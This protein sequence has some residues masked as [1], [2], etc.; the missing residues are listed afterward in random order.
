MADMQTVSTQ[1]AAY[2]VVGD[3]SQETGSIT[4][5]VG[6]SGPPMVESLQAFDRKTGDPIGGFAIESRDEPDTTRIVF[7]SR[8]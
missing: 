1:F 5:S 8:V 6:S 2:E 7:V 3:L 4:G